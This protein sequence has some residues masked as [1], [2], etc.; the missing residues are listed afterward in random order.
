MNN[1]I[2]KVKKHEARGMGVSSSARRAVEWDEFISILTAARIV[3]RDKASIM[4]LALLT[5]QWQLIARV[6]DC[7]RLAT[8]TILFNFRDPYTLWIRMCWSKNIRSEREC[9]TQYCLQQWIR[10]YALY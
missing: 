2:T 5:L 9:P 1:I 8:T 6:D 10:L 7:L 4:L 3:L